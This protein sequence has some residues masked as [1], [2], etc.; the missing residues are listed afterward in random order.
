MRADFLTR[1]W[2][3]VCAQTVLR[4][5]K[6]CAAE[7][8]VKMFND[9]REVPSWPPSSTVQRGFDGSVECFDRGIYLLAIHYQQLVAS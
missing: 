7:H 1:V 9:C 4:S 8:A 3:F 5:V 2:A 6:R